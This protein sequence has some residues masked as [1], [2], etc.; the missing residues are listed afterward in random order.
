[1]G[2]NRGL[3]P[4]FLPIAALAVLAILVINLSIANVSLASGPTPI[5]AV[6]TISK[7]GQGNTVYNPQSVTIKQGEEILILNND[8]TS[9]SFTNGMGPDDQLAGK[10]FDTGTIEPRAFIEYVASNLQPGTYPFFS[11]SDPS[12]K[13]ELVVTK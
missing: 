4:G 13:G 11:M 9:H 1:M 2:S 5:V 8:T 12:A 3:K 10:L 7:D 6:I